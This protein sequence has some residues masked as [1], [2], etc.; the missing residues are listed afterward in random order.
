[1]DPGTCPVPCRPSVASTAL[2][3]SDIR[4]FYPRRTLLKR[5]SSQENMPKKFCRFFGA[6]QES[7]QLLEH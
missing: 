6:F 7:R 3:G 1:M 4:Q 2:L 5:R